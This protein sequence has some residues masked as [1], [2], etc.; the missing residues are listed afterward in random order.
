MKQSVIVMSVLTCFHTEKIARTK[1]EVI[2]YITCTLRSH[3]TGNIHF[4][5]RK[6]LQSSACFT[7]TGVKD[8]KKI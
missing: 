2:S 6:T 8:L 3:F 5:H 7:L 4:Q 1:I